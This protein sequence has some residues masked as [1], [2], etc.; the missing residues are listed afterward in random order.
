MEAR[1]PTF[2]QYRPGERQDPRR[3][4]MSASDVAILAAVIFLA[5]GLT[6]NPLAHRYGPRLAITPGRPDDAGS[7]RCLHAG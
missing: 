4:S 5:H 1:R 2:P 7:R 6:A 3:D